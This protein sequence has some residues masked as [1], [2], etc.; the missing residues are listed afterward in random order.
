MMNILLILILLLVFIHMLSFAKYNWEQ[1]NK[2]GAVG[3]IILA[4]AALILPLVVMFF[5]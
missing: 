2:L 5:D 1:R 3:A 4:L